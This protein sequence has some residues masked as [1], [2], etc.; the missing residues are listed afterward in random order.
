MAVVT[1]GTVR[2]QVHVKSTAPA[3]PRYSR[4]DVRSVLIRGGLH[5]VIV[6]IEV[7]AGDPGDRPPAGRRL[8]AEVRDVTQV[9]AESITVASV[10]D[11]VR[12]E[13]GSWLTT[14]EVEVPAG[15]GGNRDL[16]VWA[17]VRGSARGRGVRPGDY[18]T[19]RSYPLTE[20]AEELFLTV[21]VNRV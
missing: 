4:F 10:D 19:T 20:G 16:T 18:I 2:L 21:T 11:T 17:H 13:F 14:V 5:P 1:L 3:A 6:V 7:R 9:D 8:R 15:P 12:G